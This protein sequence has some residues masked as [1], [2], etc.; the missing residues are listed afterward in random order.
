[1]TVETMLSQMSVREFELW[2][3]WRTMNND[4]AALENSG[5]TREV[6]W[7]AVFNPRKE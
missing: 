5:Q 3:A 2:K 7:N 6:A 4:V 1:M